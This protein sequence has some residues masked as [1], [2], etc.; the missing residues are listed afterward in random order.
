M[1]LP[2]AVV[3]FNSEERRP[4]TGLLSIFLF[5]FISIYAHF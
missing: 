4:L 5:M 2:K 3:S 1:I